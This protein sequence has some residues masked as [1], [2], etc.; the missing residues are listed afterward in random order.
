MKL[1]KDGRPEWMDWK[2]IKAL[3]VPDGR[4]I[5]PRPTRENK[6]RQFF[7]APDYVGDTAEV[8]ANLNKSLNRSRPAHAKLPTSVK[9]VRR[10][11]ARAHRQAELSR[12][13]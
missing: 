1:W 6:H 3:V 2:A 10:A 5:R 9:K 7:K 13:A 12:A 11:I 4:D 8:Q